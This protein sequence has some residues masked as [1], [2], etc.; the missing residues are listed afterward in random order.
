MQDS[1]FE[2]KS[3]FHDP[4]FK[5]MSDALEVAQNGPAHGPNPQV[6][7][8]LISPD[9]V[10]IGVGWH[11]G[12]GTPHAEVAAIADA[13]ANGHSTQGTTA[14]V[15]L[16]PCNHLG[17][18]GPC[19]QAL[20]AADVA[21]VLYP[22]EDPG[23]DSGGGAAALQADG[24]RV[25]TWEQW[26]AKSATDAEL[27]A[28]YMNHAWEGVRY[29]HHAMKTGRPWVTLKLA[30][31]L[32]GKVAAQAG[33]SQWITGPQAREHAHAV[34]ASL[35]AIAVTTGTALA[36]DPALTAR[37]PTGELASH[38]PLR[39]VV[40]HREIPATAKLRGAGG[41][42]LQ[43][44]THDVGEVLA[45]LHA[46]EVRHLLVEGGPALLSTF[47]KADVVD[48]IHAYVAPMLLG[49]GKN[50]VADFGIDTL[51]AAPRWV[52]RE[53]KQLGDDVFIRAMTARTVGGEK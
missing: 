48:E 45:A 34:R 4:L 30:T 16:E 42:I 22:I 28:M 36:D 35:D 11:M 47:L 37:F 27:A 15:T 21:C 12:A 8:V 29:W 17:R 33:S 44:R 5:A 41:E 18:T 14:V 13:R 51:I 25:E 1:T 52:T 32:D 6:G 24:V 3:Y 50:A 43:I 20:I 19:T 2:R 40:G 9:G 7:C 31:T 53:V 23:K 49:A 46:R 39:V 26:F 38:Q 10:K